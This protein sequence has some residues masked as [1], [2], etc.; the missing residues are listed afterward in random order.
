MPQL[1]L[2]MDVLEFDSAGYTEEL[3][4]RIRSLYRKGIRAFIVAAI[5]KVPVDTGMARGSFLNIGRLVGMSIPIHPISD[6]KVYYGPNGLRLPKTPQ[7]GA[8]LSTSSDEAL[9]FK[10]NKFVFSF[11]SKVWHYNLNEFFGL[12]SNNGFPWGSFAAG[13]EAFMKAMQTGSLFPDI[14]EYLLKSTITVGRGGGIERSSKIR[15]R[16][17]KKVKE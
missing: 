8:S 16:K 12:K 1:L 13:R 10:G 17:Q 11:Q 5:P 14:H 3:K 4:N 9:Q 7:S 6:G 15:L 2:T